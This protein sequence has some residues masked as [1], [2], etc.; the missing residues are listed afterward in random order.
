MWSLLYGPDQTYFSLYPDVL[1][2][3]DLLAGRV[4]LGVLSNWDYSL[5]RILRMLGIYD[6]FDV[7]VASLEEGPEKPDPRLFGIILERLGSTASTTLHVG[8]DAIDDLEGA[9]SS[10]L[11]AVLIDRSRPDTLPPFVNTLTA[12]PGVMG[13]TS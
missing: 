3:L 5:H 8:D 4:K 10:G 7:V 11:S 6:R 2:A 12:L 13:W 9:R 1:P